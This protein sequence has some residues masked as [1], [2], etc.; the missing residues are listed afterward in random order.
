MKRLVLLVGIPGCGKTTLANQLVERG[1]RRL[2]ADDIREELFGTAVDSRNPADAEKV[3]AQFFARLE[4]ALA[5]SEDIVVDNTNINSK[6]RGPILQRAIR[7][8]YEDI[9]LWILDVPLEICIQR[10]H[11]R[12][13]RIPD[14]VLQNYFNT[15]NGRGRPSKHEGKL[16]VVR[17]AEEAFKFRFFPVE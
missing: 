16:I 17:P 5:R 15:L 7:A 12:E 13:R 10:N 2:N 11:E 4:Q 6:H 9:Q 1:Y 3:F 14:D 8:G